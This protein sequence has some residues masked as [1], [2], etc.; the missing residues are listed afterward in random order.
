MKNRFE[1]LGYQAS[2]DRLIILLASVSLAIALVSAGQVRTV[3]VGIFSILAIVLFIRLI[4][5]WSRSSRK[6]NP[7]C[8]RGHE[9]MNI[10]AELAN[11]MNVNL[12]PTKPLEV[13]PELR[14]AKSTPLP[15]F[16]DCRVHFAGRVRIGCTILCDLDNLA[17]KGILAHELAH[18]R[19]NH[20]LKGL[21]SL[22]LF[23]PVLAYWIASRSTP[24]I[25][26]LLTFAIWTLVFS[27]ISW[28]HE[29]EADS[30]AAEYV[31]KEDMAYA[32]EQIQ[33]LIYRPGDT[34]VHPSF[35]KRI[36]RLLPDKE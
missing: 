31:G 4:I 21:P 27:L 26:I 20:S 36:S 16:S 17:L 2:F 13:V 23:V 5:Y 30:V 18:L 34:L 29:Y 15:F 14:G 28:H 11:E 12:H 8:H 3:S 7:D 19:K 1:H 10:M 22:L 9:A 35:K 32:L 6:N 24:I 33:R 25:P